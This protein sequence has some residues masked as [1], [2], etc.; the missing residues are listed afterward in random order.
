[1]IE[2]KD[3][4]EKAINFDEYR[5]DKNQY[6]E[7]QLRGLEIGIEEKLDVSVYSNPLL[8]FLQMRELRKAMEQ[9]INIL[10]FVKKNFG[11]EILNRLEKPTKTVLS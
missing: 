8:I 2:E 3:I 10:P 4:A 5:I 7:L 11:T 9:G 1:M 6:D